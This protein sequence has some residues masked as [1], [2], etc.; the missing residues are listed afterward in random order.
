MIPKISASFNNIMP[1]KLVAKGSEDT[2]K[3]QTPSILMKCNPYVLDNKSERFPEFLFLS[4]I[5][6]FL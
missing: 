3:F 6:R 5:L 4:M 2:L 1:P